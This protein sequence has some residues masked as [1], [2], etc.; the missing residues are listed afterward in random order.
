MTYIDF[1]INTTKMYNHPNNAEGWRLGQAVY[2]RL[3]EIRPDIA[4]KI[5]GTP[6]DPYYKNSV[7]T[8]TWE[9]IHQN[10]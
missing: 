6:L 5:V 3:H 9:F 10:W 1:V 4:N 7:T 8:E 2:N